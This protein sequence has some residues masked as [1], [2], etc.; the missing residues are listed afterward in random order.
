MNKKENQQNYRAE[1]A[2]KGVP[3]SPGITI[4][5]A[6]VY[7]EPT[8]EPAPKTITSSQVPSELKRFRKAVEKSHQYLTKIRQEALVQHGE[9]FA[10][11]I[12]IQIAILEDKIFLAEVEELIRKE[13]YDA[14]YATFKVFRNKKEHFLQLSDQ[15]F[16]DRAFDVQSVKRL[17]LRNLL[18]KKLDV[19]LTDSS[20]VVASDLS[21]ADTIRLHRK[22]ILG[23]CTD[24]GGKNS[25][26]AIIAR[27][28]GVPAVV[29]LEYI[30]NLVETG[31][32][33]IL[34]GRE[35]IIIINPS[36]QTIN[37]YRK[38]Q[39]KF[40]IFYKKLVKTAQVPAVTRDGTP[41]EVLANIEFL[42]EIKHLKKF[43]AEGVGLFR[44]E[45]LFMEGNGLPSEDEQAKIY[46]RLANSLKGKPV[47]IRTLDIGGDKILPDITGTMEQNPF[48]GWRA[49]RFC[50]DHKEI[51]IPQLKAI[52][53]ANVHGNVHILVPMI[54]TLREL[55]EFK[56]VLQVAKN[57]LHK[58][59]KKF[60]PDIKIGIMVEVPSVA[61][62][63][64]VFAREVDFFSIGTNDLLQYT[65]A[66]DRGNRRI[67]HLYSH[68]NPALLHLIQLILD[69]GKK[70]NIP[71]SM[72][73]EMAGDLVAVPLL[74]GMGL[75]QFSAATLAI[76]EVK[77]VIRNVSLKDCQELY[78]EVKRKKTTLE[79]QKVC[80]DFFKQ[81]F[82]EEVPL[83]VNNDKN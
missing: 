18:G 16:H 57:L 40:Q 69:A 47:I 82:K 60:N 9:E 15:Y 26:T 44:T 54:S 53:R 21:P 38:K 68:F 7:F 56:K 62:M 24:L 50:L 78:K 17:L 5:P 66:V 64:D 43:G 46:T 2:V 20:I 55:H 33:L 41:I 63:A 3:A 76:P 4:G 65:L 28:L 12:E 67:A 70:A 49:I 45:G 58:E 1:I 13:L 34:D 48:L 59:G 29:G 80:E 25:H 23:F 75:R 81:I 10:E 52:L 6:F 31:D 8:F 35:G 83:L 42:D 71:V 22:H 73:G 74:L 51:F 37:E 39:K 61:I 27:S 19:L 36:Q 14:P 72:C 77:N 30:T 11:I 79:I 32:R